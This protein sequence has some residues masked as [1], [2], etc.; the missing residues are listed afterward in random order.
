V[1]EF[2][3]SYPTPVRTTDKI[4][5]WKRPICPRVYGLPAH[6]ADFIVARLKAIARNAGAPVNADPKCRQNIEI[7]FTTTP[8][9]IGDDLRKKRW[10]YLGYFDNFH[11]A[12]ELAKV[13]HDIQAWYLTATEG[14]NGFVRV[15][16]PRQDFLTGAYGILGGWSGDLPAGGGVYYA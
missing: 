2:V 16:N 9:A 5:R 6:F 12:D 4:A 11:Q 7:V 1:D 3:Y 8:Q 10:A 15:D 13:S 14:N